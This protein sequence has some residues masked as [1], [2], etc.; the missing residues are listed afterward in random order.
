MSALTSFVQ[1]GTGAFGQRKEVKFSISADDITLYTEN[2]MKPSKK[3][4]LE[5]INKFGQ[6]ERYK[7]NI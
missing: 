7:I 1:H 3:K 5:L 6:V 4:L 2:P